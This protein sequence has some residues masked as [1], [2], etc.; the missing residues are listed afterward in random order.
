MTYKQMKR[1]LAFIREMQIKASEITLRTHWSRY[2]RKPQEVMR[3]ENLC[4]LVSKQYH[5]T[6]VTKGVQKPEFSSVVVNGN[7]KW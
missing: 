6:T 4:F 1:C 3:L 7:V 5:K 2:N